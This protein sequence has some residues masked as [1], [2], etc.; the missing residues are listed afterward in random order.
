MS[1]KKEYTEECLVNVEFENPN[2]EMYFY[3]IFDNIEAAVKKNNYKFVVNPISKH[4]D[5]IIINS[6]QYNNWKGKISNLLKQCINFTADNKTHS[7]SFVAHFSDGTGF[8]IIRGEGDKV[9]RVAV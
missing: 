4:Y 5:V 8:R 7:V 1:K 2:D 6:G 3:Y 9:I